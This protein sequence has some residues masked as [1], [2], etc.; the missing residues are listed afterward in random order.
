MNSEPKKPQIDRQA[1]LDEWWKETMDELAAEKDKLYLGVGD[2]EDDRIEWENEKRRMEEEEEEMFREAKLKGYI[3][4]VD[5]ESDED[6]E[7]DDDDDDEFRKI[8]NTKNWCGR[9]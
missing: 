3:S 2:D 4:W 9:A 1:M 7:E 6:E 5:E 8:C